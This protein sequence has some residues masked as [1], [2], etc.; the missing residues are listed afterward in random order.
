M[1]I[2]EKEFTEAFTPP[3][4]P[5][6]EHPPTQQADPDPSGSGPGVHIPHGIPVPGG[7]AI[8]LQNPFGSDGPLMAIV[9]VRPVYPPIAEQRGLEGYVIVRFD[10]LP[11][12]AVSNVS[13]VESSSSLFERAAITAAKGFRFKAQVV[14]GEPQMSTGV[15]YQFRFTMPG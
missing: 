9:R 3:K 6:I 10:V 2:D 11:S 1:D 15:Q 14:D 5:P 4:L 13:V 8:G 7:P 12:G